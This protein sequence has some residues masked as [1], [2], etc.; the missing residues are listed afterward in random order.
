MGSIAAILS[1]SGPPDAGAA[2]RMLAASP[3]R[4]CVFDL[5]TCRDVILGVSNRSDAV[6]S[7]ISTRGDLT[8]AFCGTLD[9]ALQLTRDLTAAGFPPASSSVADIVVSAWRAF[10][11]DAPNRLRGIFAGIVT[12]GR[13]LWTFRD[14]LE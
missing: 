7:A 14:H 4:G 1:R 6:D 11:S 9:N 13:Q 5:R 10:G 8:A 12:D 3:H 2:R